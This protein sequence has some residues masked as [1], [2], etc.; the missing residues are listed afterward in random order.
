VEASVLAPLD[1]A[2]FE[3]PEG[4]AIRG[5]KAI[6]GYAFTGQIESVDLATGERTPLASAP[7][8]PPN[9]AFMTGVDADADGR[10]LAAYVSFTPDAAPGI[11][12]TAVGGGEAALWASHP[13]MILPNGLA[14]GEDGTLFVA[15]SVYG[16][17][18]TVDAD[19]TVNPWAQDAL[20]AGMPE[21]CGQTADSLSVGANGVVWTPDG[22]LVASSN[23][24]LL[25]KFPFEADGSAGPL[26]VLSGPDCELL[27]GIDGI[28]VDED[29]TILGAVNRSNTI[30]RIDPAGGI[31]P[32][33]Q[34]APLDFPASLA[35]AGTGSGRGL[36]VSSFALDSYLSGGA[37]APAVVKLTLP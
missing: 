17:I 1:A 4:L 11:Y 34:G 7:P 2:A 36:Y 22:L 8:P 14:W 12:R 27:G 25:A 29:G 6:V 35:L 3:L 15:D 23:Q 5:D 37:P 13:D 31:E 33:F 30:V 10:I 19:G 16:G 21:A 28:A 26:A 20:L 9:T 32:I 24:A 18:F